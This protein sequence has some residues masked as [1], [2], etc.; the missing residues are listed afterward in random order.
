M[1][2]AAQSLLSFEQAT[3][4]AEN[5]ARAARTA[6][7]RHEREAKQAAKILAA[8]Q[9]EK[10]KAEEEAAKSWRRFQRDI[11]RRERTPDEHAQCGIRWYCRSQ[12]DRDRGCYWTHCH[13][14][15]QR[16]IYTSDPNATPQVCAG[17]KQ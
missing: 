10:R 7:E 6:A 15:G 17:H 3:V 1:N 8:I 12:R 5:L 9:R 16:L 11:A 13:A 2:T 4:D 14:C